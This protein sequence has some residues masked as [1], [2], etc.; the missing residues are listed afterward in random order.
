MKHLEFVQNA[1]S[2]MGS[3]NANLKGYCM[4]M[5]AAVIGLSAAVSKEQIIIY[6]LPIVITFSVLDAAYLSLERGFRQ[7][8]DSIRRT[9][10]DTEPDFYVF[11][12]YSGIIKSYFSWSV[13]GFYG[14]I[15]IIMI[16]IY[17]IIPDIVKT[18]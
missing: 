11:S 10:L 8:F 5:V 3:N 17:S 14:A 6:S 12:S 9:K 16:V 7:N 15:S 4:T 1:I 18:N 13:V 2:R